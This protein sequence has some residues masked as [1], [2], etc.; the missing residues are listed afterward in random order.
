MKKQK[1]IKDVGWA[2]LLAAYIENNDAD[3]ILEREIKPFG[4][5]SAH[6]SGIDAKHIGKT[7]RIIIKRRRD[8]ELPKNDS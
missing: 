6:I 5:T 1:P 4:G 3:E 8:K 2:E 7:A